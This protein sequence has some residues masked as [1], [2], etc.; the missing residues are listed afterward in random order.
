[1][2]LELNLDTLGN[3][4]ETDLPRKPKTIERAFQ[5]AIYTIKD[6]SIVIKNGEVIYGYVGVCTYS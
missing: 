3:Q 6:G 4:E 1:M 5:R 2:F